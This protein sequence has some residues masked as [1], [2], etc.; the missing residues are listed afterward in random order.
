M[1]NA[2]RDTGSD[3]RGD[4]QRSVYERFHDRRRRMPAPSGG[5]GRSAFA[6]RWAT[7]RSLHATR[8]AGH[9]RPGV[10]VRTGATSRPSTVWNRGQALGGP[11]GT[12]AFRPVDDAGVATVVILN[13]GK[14]TGS[15][16]GSIRPRRDAAVDVLR[17]DRSAA[18]RE[19]RF[20]VAQPRCG[21][22]RGDDRAEDVAGTGAA[23]EV[24][25]TAPFLRL[26]RRATL[27]QIAPRV[28]DV[29]HEGQLHLE[30][31]WSIR[32]RP[33]AWER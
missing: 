21:A 1:L 7:H 27:A 6:A 3:E 2:E 4:E 8:C 31:F 16:V 13:S 9:A 32:T 23:M 30:P 26:A 15:V 28:D 10:A 17:A 20:L 33:T 22:R 11:P 24:Y 25:S 14:G 5:D 12:S 19:R 18:D 29:A